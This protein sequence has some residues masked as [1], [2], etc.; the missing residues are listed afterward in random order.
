MNIIICS[1]YL[2][3]Y[4]ICLII[5]SIAEHYIY[6]LIY[7]NRSLV[8][9]IYQLDLLN[10]VHLTFF[11]YYIIDVSGKGGSVQTASSCCQD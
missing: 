9:I 7:D 2:I 11:A 8:T 3:M 10:Q 1:I 5:Y 4:A 6:M